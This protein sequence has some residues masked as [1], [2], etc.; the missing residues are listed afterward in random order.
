M[1]RP[2]LEKEQKDERGSTREFVVKLKEKINIEQARMKTQVDS[3]LKTE[4]DDGVKVQL[5]KHDLAHSSKMNEVGK[6]VQ[7]KCKAPGL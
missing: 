7:Q 4:L 6:E 3:V 1:L 5:S 2:S